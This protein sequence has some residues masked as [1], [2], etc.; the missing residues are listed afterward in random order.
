MSFE[1]SIIVAIVEEY[2]PS[3]VKLASYRSLVII[4]V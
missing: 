4:E 2:L 3:Q 1:K